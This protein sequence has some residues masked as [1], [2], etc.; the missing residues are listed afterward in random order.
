MNRRR[1]LQKS[2]LGA[3]VAPGLA[4]LNTQASS[5]VHLSCNLYTWHTYYNREGRN[6]YSDWDTSLEEVAASGV[7]GIEPALNS[8][9]QVALIGQLIDKHGLEMRSIYVN[10]KLHEAD[11]VQE[12][13][14]TVWAIAGRCKLLGTTLVV[15]NPN[16]IQWGGD[17][18]KSDEQLRIQA[19]ALNKLGRG[20]RQRGMTLAYHTHDTE[21]RAGAREFHHM[22]LA[23][24]P[25]YVSFCLDAHWVYRGALN[26]NIALFDVIKLYGDRIA[27]I[28]IRQSQNHIWSETFGAGD[29]DYVRIAEE[30]RGMGVRPFLVLEQAVE[31]GTPRTMKALDA[32]LVSQK[33]VRRV[34]R[35]A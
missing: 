27:E 19:D 4:R 7:D 15:T 3:A 6:F 28:H 25:E 8:T 32:H 24:D 16:P 31:E 29:I 30:L 23:T 10:S 35:E 34:F 5:D 26:S 14:E 22:M 17:Q 13:I 33:E 21:F 1:F 18:D 20:L 11:E 9:A 12:S 2:A